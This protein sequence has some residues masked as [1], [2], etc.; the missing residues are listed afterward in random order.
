M[1]KAPSPHPVNREIINQRWPL[2]YKI[3]AGASG[4][5][6]VAYDQHVPDATLLIDGIHLSSC[7]DQLREAE[8]Q[9]SLVPA[10][11]SAAWVYGVGSGHV[12]RILLQ[13]SSLKKLVVVIMNHAVAWQSFKHF[14]HSDWL[15][16]SRVDLVLAE[17]EHDMHTPFAAIPSC[18]QLASDEASRLRD[19]V[20]LELSTPFTQQQ[21]HP[22]NLELRQRLQENVEFV[23]NDGDVTELFG[24]Q[25]NKTILVA[26][27]GPTLSCHYEWLLSQQGSIPL[28]A[29]D[30][31]LKPLYEAGI[32]P[33]IIMTIDANPMVLDFFKNIDLQPFQTRPLVYFPVV[34]SAVLDSWPGPRM[35]SYADTVLYGELR[36]KFPKG[37]LFSSGTVLTPAVDL[38]VKMGATEVILLGADF[39]FPEGQSHVAGFP[40]LIEK[41]SSPTGHW[42]LNGYGKRVPTGAN[43][44]GY[45][46]DFERYIEQHP[47][48]R[49]LNGSKNGAYIQG[50]SYLEDVP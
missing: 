34:Y 21:H 5:H 4:L 36:D 27:A 48:V 37:S 33:D 10:E 46:R 7:Y 8:L 20:F 31:A 15:S 24:T 28:I 2:I 18:L 50:T 13:R 16:D 11:S 25:E 38:A 40:F 23:R 47:K 19:L 22:E 3:L 14:D 49:F 39:S 17:A 1:K 41:E 43:Y 30:A 42:V 44:R 35:T 45:L 9:A 32:Q 29:V 6:D 12:P 26:A